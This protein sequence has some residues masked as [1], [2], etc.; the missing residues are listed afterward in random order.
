[1][2]YNMLKKPLFLFIF[3]LVLLNVQFLLVTP[4][5][6]KRTIQEIPSS[7]QLKQSSVGHTYNITTVNKTIQD[8]DTVVSPVYYLH[9]G[10]IIMVNFTTIPLSDPNSGVILKLYEPLEVNQLT[11]ELHN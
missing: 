2:G 10:D 6:P 8:W 11:A 7:P 3:L 4:S 9:F 5:F 1:M